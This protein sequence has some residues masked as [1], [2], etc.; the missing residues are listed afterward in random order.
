MKLKHVLS[1]GY[2]SLLL[3]PNLSFSQEI[4]FILECKDKNGSFEADNITGDLDM[5]TMVVYV[6]NQL[7]T[8]CATMAENKSRAKSTNYQY[9][10]LVKEYPN[11]NIRFTL[12]DKEDSGTTNV[13]N[14]NA[15]KQGIKFS[16]PPSQEN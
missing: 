12:L 4:N 14:I 6:S 8:K 16:A 3:L 1:I 5:V 9:Y 13:Q 11:V 15:N 2:A 10:A 7:Y